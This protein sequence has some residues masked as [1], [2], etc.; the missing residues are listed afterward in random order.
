MNQSEDCIFCNIAN[1]ATPADIIFENDQLMV[2]ND[3]LPK[4]PVHVLVIPKM[5]IG[6]INEL[7]ADS[8]AI[9]ADLVMTAQQQARQLG[10]S[11]TGYKL[12]F[13]VG[14]DGGQ[15][16]KHVHLHLIGGKKLAE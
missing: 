5:H 6:S 11:E 14:R 10:I 13:N 9:V 4:A 16:I 1:K 7:T 3:I 2:L 15:T 8:Q 12:I